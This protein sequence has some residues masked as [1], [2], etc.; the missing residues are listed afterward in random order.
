VPNI[1]DFAD[2]VSEISFCILAFTDIVF[3]IST[4][5]I[6]DLTLTVLEL[7]SFFILDLA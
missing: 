4:I 7:F 6:L 2:I 5:C 3:S 1:L